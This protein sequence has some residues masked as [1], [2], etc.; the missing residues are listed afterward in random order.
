MINIACLQIVVKTVKALTKWFGV[1]IIVIAVAA[2]VSGVNRFNEP[3]VNGFEVKSIS[4]DPH[5]T[6][7]LYV[8]IVKNGLYK[9]VDGGAHWA[10]R[11]FSATDDIIEIEID[12]HDKSSIYIGTLKHIKSLS[13]NSN[14]L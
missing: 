13:I 4:V 12:P 9:S 7:V 8:G 14:S 10:N 6:N 1:L 2:I 3:S 11:R 5:N